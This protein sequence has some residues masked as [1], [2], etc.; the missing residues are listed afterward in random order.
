MLNTRKSGIFEGKQKYEKRGAT[1]YTGIGLTILHNVYVTYA[2]IKKYLIKLK[3]LLR[4]LLKK[5]ILNV[6]LCLIFI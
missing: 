3:S 1:K 5:V 4:N 6:F 2:L